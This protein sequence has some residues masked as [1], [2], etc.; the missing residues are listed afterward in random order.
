MDYTVEVKQLEPQLTGV[1][2]F[3]ASIPD[4]PKVIPQACGE[5]WTFFRAS[6]LPKP[7]RN[8]AVY[9]DQVM[10]IECGV[11]VEQ[12][13]VG[14]DRVV[15]SKSPAGL[16]ATTAHWGPYHLLPN[17]YAAIKKWCAAHGHTLCGAGWE[18]YGHWTDDPTQLRT[19]VYMLLKAPKAS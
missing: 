6:G 19:D 14:N 17:A 1:V 13:F 10:N 12:P 3:Q 8:I 9:L 18:V 5:V 2:R 7:G 15:C 16:A 4:L 11:E